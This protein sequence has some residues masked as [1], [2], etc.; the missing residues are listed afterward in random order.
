MSPLLEIP[1]ASAKVSS[2]TPKAFCRQHISRGPGSVGLEGKLQRKIFLRH[3]AMTKMTT[4]CYRYDIEIFPLKNIRSL[5][6][7]M[8]YKAKP[9]RSQAADN[10]NLTGI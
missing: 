7:T 10:L 3:K 2:G 6:E 8:R 4:I 5:S 9:E 1:L